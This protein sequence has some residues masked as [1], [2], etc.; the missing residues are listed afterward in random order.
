MMQFYVSR[1]SQLDSKPITF[2]KVAK[3]VLHA[4]CIPLIELMQTW[5]GFAAKI[6]SGHETRRLPKLHTRVRFPS[7]APITAAGA[8]NSRLLMRV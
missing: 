6:L 1:E 5:A 7:P 3:I 8:A 2:D 4:Q